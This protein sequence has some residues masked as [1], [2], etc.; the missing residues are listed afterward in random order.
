MKIGNTGASPAMGTAAGITSTPRETAE[1][2]KAGTASALAS[3][4]DGS[5]TV[6]I[7]SA[8]SE[9]LGGTEGTFDAEKVARVRQSIS[10]GSYKVNP[11][12]IADKLISNAQD[13]LGK[14]GSNG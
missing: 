3:G 2:A 11:E 12:A 6:K 7:S 8:A 4:K 14:I 13:V 1:T 5:T 9:L 10:D